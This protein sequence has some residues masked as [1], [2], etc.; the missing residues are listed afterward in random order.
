MQYTRLKANPLA[1][2]DDAI[3][4]VVDNTYALNTC[5]WTGSAWANRNT[6]DTAIDQYLYRAF[7]FAWEASGSKGLLVY[8]TT[9]GQITYRTFT[10]PNTWGSITNVAM[11]TSDHTW[12]QARTNPSPQ[13]GGTKILGAASDNTPQDL[14][15]FR[16]DGTTFTVIGS[17]TF[18]TDT[19]GFM[20][21]EMFDLKYPD[22][23]LGGTGEIRNMVCKDLSVSNCDAPSE[24]T[25]WDGS[26]GIDTVAMGVASGTYPSLATTWDTN[27][28]LWVGYEK[29]VNATS[30]GIYA[31]FLDY[32]TGG[33]QSP[34][35]IDT[36]S[37]TV[38]TRPSI[39]VDKDNNVHALYVSTS[40]PQL[41]YKM[42]S[43]GIWGSRTAVDTSSDFPSLMV[44]AP[45]DAMYGAA[46]GAVYWKTS[47][48][49]TYFYYIP[50]F[51]SVVATIFG[52]IGLVLLFGRR[53]RS[54]P[55][56]SPK[57]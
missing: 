42:R 55:R 31:R 43:G 33:W 41:Y 51:G 46:S 23:R 38:F 7:D 18:S 22:V 6:H 20:A 47:T 52:T 40:G 53:V 16:W 25:K 27:G 34:E 32:P 12:I 5:Y 50:E 28:D 36:L 48:S 15:A 57:T 8:S 14:G 13:T 2:A 26:T 11:G 37:G 56:R 54:K 30:R 1:T 19:G 17:G 9:A 21:N 4:T 10:A 39:G 35:T 49:E 45:N 29:D 3:V 24:F 44:R